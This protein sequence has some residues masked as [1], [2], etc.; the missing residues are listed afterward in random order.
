[1]PPPS[2]HLLPGASGAPGCPLIALLPRSVHFQS[3][4]P[5]QKIFLKPACHPF[6]ESP[7]LPAHVSHLESRI[8][9]AGY[10]SCHLSKPP[11]GQ[12]LQMPHMLL[13]CQLMP[14]MCS[15]CFLLNQQGSAHTHSSYSSQIQSKP[16]PLNASLT[17]ILPWR[18]LW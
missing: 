8:G 7:S 14:G 11:V 12:S 10:S 3:Q 18:T 15:L 4:Y 16:S 5:G 13:S 2:Q 17:L 6:T 1:M 9:P